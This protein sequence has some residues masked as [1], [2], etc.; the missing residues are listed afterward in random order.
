MALSPCHGLARKAKDKIKTSKH[1]YQEPPES[2]D[3]S[4]EDISPEMEGGKSI[5]I[6]NP[7]QIAYKFNLTAAY[8]FSQR[9]FTGKV[10]L[11]KK[12]LR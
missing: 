11:K 8:N 5:R 3:P 9:Y 2:H 7:A 1:K 10:N 4:D 12:S 6:W